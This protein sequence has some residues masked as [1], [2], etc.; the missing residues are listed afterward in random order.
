MADASH[1][2]C[3][4]GTC[5]APPTR[6]H[7]QGGEATGNVHLQQ[8]HSSTTT[9]DPTVGVQPR[10]DEA[11]HRARRAQKRPARQSRLGP[12]APCAQQR[13]ATHRG[14]VAAISSPKCSG[15]CTRKDSRSRPQAP[16]ANGR[17]PPPA[18]RC[19]RQDA[20][21]RAGN[22]VVLI[23]EL[24]GHRRLET[25]KRWIAA[26]LLVAEST[27]GLVRRALRRQPAGARGARP[28]RRGIRCPGGRPAA[29][30]RRGVTYGRIPCMNHVTAAPA[31]IVPEAGGRCCLRADL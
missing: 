9:S 5:T 10:D 3:T 14:K 7:D 13:S 24:A 4:A 18:A 17:S 16:S 1:G 30:A 12:S 28:P 6:W 22:D 8:P 20:L 31:D 26:G 27:G 19:S 25:T 15:C 29:P 21:V 23:A 11:A 2:S